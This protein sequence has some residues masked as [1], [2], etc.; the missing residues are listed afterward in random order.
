MNMSQHNFHISKTVYL[1]VL[2]AQFGIC[3]T[4]NALSQK[5]KVDVALQLK[6][7]NQRATMMSNMPQMNH[8]NI[9]N[10]DSIS[11]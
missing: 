7:S 6:P 4:H 1:Y 3:S 11:L 9:S 8:S 2:E 10:Q 5:A